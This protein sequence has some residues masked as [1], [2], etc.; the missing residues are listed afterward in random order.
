MP[1]VESLCL[2]FCGSNLTLASPHE[3]PGYDAFEMMVGHDLLHQLSNCTIQQTGEKT[4]TQLGVVAKSENEIHESELIADQDHQSTKQLKETLNTTDYLSDT[5][6]SCYSEILNH[7]NTSY[8]PFLDLELSRFMLEEMFPIASESIYEYPPEVKASSYYCVETSTESQQSKMEQHEQRPQ[9]TMLDNDIQRIVEETF[10]DTQ[11][12]MEA[13]G[14]APLSESDL[15]NFL[16]GESHGGW[17]ED[18]QYLQVL[19]MDGAAIGD[20]LI[21]GID[22]DLEIQS[23]TIQEQEIDKLSLE[24]MLTSELATTKDI[25]APCFT[26]L[27]PTA[28]R[29][30]KKTAGGKKERKG[31]NTKKG[32][33]NPMMNEESL[34][35]PRGIVPEKEIVSSTTTTTTYSPSPRKTKQKQQIENEEAK[36]KP[37]QQSQE[38]T[39]DGQQNPPSSSLFSLSQFLGKD[40]CKSFSQFSYCLGKIQR[41]G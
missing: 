39:I 20:Q 29:T 19:E 36:A 35:K 16:E 27:T 22:A 32:A 23:S 26:A 41:P 3:D 2:P 18:L 13:L 31:K 9:E 11:S 24:L 17:I 4:Y 1:Q 33:E 15:Q 28:K 10:S 25:K 8:T 21:N 38:K 5:S 30:R 34:I 14:E 12:Y 7:P 40:H 37:Q 6:S